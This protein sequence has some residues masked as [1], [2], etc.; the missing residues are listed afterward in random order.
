MRTSAI[1]LVPV[2]CAA[3]IGLFV[4]VALMLV[5]APAPEPVVFCPQE[6][7]CAVD[8]RDGAWHVEEVSP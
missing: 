7:S 2:F 6:D 1:D 4:G 8:Y 3:V 5:L